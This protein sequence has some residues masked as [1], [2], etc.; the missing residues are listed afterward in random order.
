MAKHLRHS[1]AVKNAQIKG[2]KVEYFSGKYGQP[3]FAL[4][5]CGDTI[6]GEETHF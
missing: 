1:V 5:A 4:H 2:E 6:V 3:F